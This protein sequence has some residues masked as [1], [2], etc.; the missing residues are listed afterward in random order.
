M[1]SL[2][3]ITKLLNW[4]L[5]TQQWLLICTWVISRW[6]SKFKLWNWFLLI[7]LIQQSW[8]WCFEFVS[9]RFTVTCAAQ[10]CLVIWK[11]V[12]DLCVLWKA[13]SYEQNYPSIT[14]IQWDTVCLYWSMYC[15]P[16]VTPTC[17]A[18][19]CLFAY[20]SL[21]LLSFFV[22]SGNSNNKI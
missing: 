3:F 5:L 4:S 22:S 8:F 19:A 1:D 14:H 13:Q 11:R 20:L 10:H 2:F 7:W 15:T 9:C 21:I 12:Q 17:I 18:V 6:P 16:V